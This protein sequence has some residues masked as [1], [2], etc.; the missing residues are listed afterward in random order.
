MVWFVRHSSRAF[1]SQC[2]SDARPVELFFFSMSQV[3]D[4][5]KFWLSLKKMQK[6]CKTQRWKTC[7]YLELVWSKWLHWPYR[8]VAYWKDSSH[9]SLLLPEISLL[10]LL[11]LHCNRRFG[12]CAGFHFSC[13][14]C[15]LFVLP[16]KH[17]QY[18]RLSGLAIRIKTYLLER[19]CILW[20]QLKCW[21]KGDLC[22]LSGFPVSIKM[23]AL[24]TSMPDLN[25]LVVGVC[26]LKQ[27]WYV[28]WMQN[29]FRWKPNCAYVLLLDLNFTLK[30]FKNYL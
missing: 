14:V 11:T 30:V 28:N 6:L 25:G 12:C 3:S 16:L 27:P 18:C 20:G 17:I 1:N 13:T 24:A 10:A 29:V 9:C 2:I 7:L 26:V 8:I 4:I 5:L 15:G 19:L 21:K 22:L 23:C